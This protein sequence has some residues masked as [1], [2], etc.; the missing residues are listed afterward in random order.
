[1]S[2]GLRWMT[3]CTLL[4]SAFCILQGCSKEASFEPLFELN[5]GE[6]LRSD[7]LEATSSTWFNKGVSAGPARSS[8]RMTV[9]TWNGYESR[10][11]LRFTAFPDTSV[12]IDS[13]L[14]Y[15]WAN[16]ID[17]DLGGAVVDI[18]ALVDTLKQADLYWGDMPGISPE[19][20]ADFTLPSEPGSVFVDVTGVVTSWIR[21]EG[22]NYGFALKA[23]DET[24]PQF[25]VEFATREV[26]VKKIDDSTSLDLRPA[27]RIAFT[28]TA[29]AEQRA[30]SI[31]TEDTFADTLATPFPEDELRL[32]CGSGFPSRAFVKFDIDRIP[33]GSTVTKSVMS[34][35]LD[36]LT[37]SF[38]SLGISCYAV[39]DTA[40]RGFDTK[41]GASGTGAITLKAGEIGDDR[42]VDMVITGLVQPLVARIESNRGFVIKP[43]NEV[44]ALDFVRFWSHHQPDHYLRP[45]LVVDYV[46]PPD[47]PYPEEVKR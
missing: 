9:C 19:P 42:V 8:T 5:Q 41:I 14:L 44:F 27:L 21:G 43:S 25:I 35:T 10:G 15:L 37:S 16:W 40:W 23:R 2:D 28:D 46:L 29:G 36:S 12:T 45:R 18:H 6:R 17:G 7:T 22:H 38:D 31:A 34:L 1:M 47:L 30:V 24:G 39:V 33:E 13:V 26:S 4:L 3:I 32:L 20:L 11:F